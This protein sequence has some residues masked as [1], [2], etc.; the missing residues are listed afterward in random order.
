MYTQ[1]ATAD[2]ILCF[3]YA[4]QAFECLTHLVDILW[5]VND[6]KHLNHSYLIG[7]AC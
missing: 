7:K 1:L 4:V 3:G 2:I 5:D 6:N